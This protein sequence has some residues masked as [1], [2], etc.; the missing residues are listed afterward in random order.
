MSSHG[1]GRGIARQRGHE[2]ALTHKVLVGDRI[3]VHQGHARG[4][5]R[6]SFRVS[7]LV[8]GRRRGRS[9]SSL[10]R[11]EEFRRVLVGA[12]AQGAPFDV[13]SGL[14]VSMV[15]RRGRRRRRDQGRTRAGGAD[16]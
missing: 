14:P 5:Q 15:P 7:W 8:A 1:S 3:V 11:A 13:R 12:V 16:E 2:R 10:E 4:A 9:F 6:C